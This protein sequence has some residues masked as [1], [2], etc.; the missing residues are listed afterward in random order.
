MK[1]I[2][3]LFGII[4]VLGLQSFAETKEISNNNSFEE[5]KNG[6]PFQW[7]INTIFKKDNGMGTLQI[8]SESVQDGKNCLMIKNETKQFFHLYGTTIGIDA[9]DVI[10]M[11]VY[12]KGKGSFSLSVYMY[13]AKNV[14]LNNI[15]PKAVKVEASN[16]GKKDF[17]IT[18]PTNEFGDKGK[19]ANIRPV[20]VVD[21]DSEI[22]IDNFSG[23]IEKTP[24]PAATGGA[25]KK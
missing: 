17:E 13:N 8:I 25:D 4:C 6:V 15:Y 20:I 21:P 11:S 7:T 16:W 12:V 23:Q 10:K 19:V 1:K 18:V 9:G 22:Y 24:A 3:A 5:I 2:I 14:W